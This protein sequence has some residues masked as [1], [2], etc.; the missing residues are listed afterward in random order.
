MNR[1]PMCPVC[2]ESVADYKGPCPKPEAIMALED[3]AAWLQRGREA[4]DELI[5][6]ELQR[7]SAFFSRQKPLRLA[8]LPL[9]PLEQDRP[10][11][12]QS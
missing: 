8:V 9:P 1:E 12:G 10:S 2:G 4:Q 3:L 6:K 5:T 11:G 7:I